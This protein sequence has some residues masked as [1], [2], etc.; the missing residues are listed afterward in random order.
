MDRVVGDGPS[1]RWDRGDIVEME[2]RWS[3]D[4]VEM[5]MEIE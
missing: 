1:G 3:G 5:E 4:R 2:W